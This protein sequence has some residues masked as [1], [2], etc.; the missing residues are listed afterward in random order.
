M[1]AGKPRRSA[2]TQR[3]TGSGL[4]YAEPEQARGIRQRVRL[5][6]VASDAL[7][8]D[9]GLDEPCQISQR[10]LPAEIAGLDWY[11]VRQARLDDV[12]FGA[13]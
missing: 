8:I 11:G 13:N 7:L 12:H 9:L 2:W 6:E 10:L 5:K 1:T 4:T 3:K